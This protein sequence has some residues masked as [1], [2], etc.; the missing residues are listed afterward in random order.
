MYERLPEW[1]Q[2]VAEYVIETGLKNT[3]IIAGV[4]VVLAVVVGVLL[5]TLLTIRFLPLQAAIRLYI[6]VWRGLPIIVT[7]FLLFFALPTVAD[8]VHLSALNLDTMR[9]A[10]LGLALWGSAQIA[11]ATRGA[12]QSIPREQHEASAALGFGWIGRHTYVIL[13]QASRRLLPPLVGLCVGVIQNSTLAAIIGVPEVLETAQRSTNRL[14]VPTVDPATLAIEGGDSHA[15]EIY[16]GIFFL[17]FLI[18][19]PLTRLAAYLEKKL[20]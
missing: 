6:E 9:A 13:P 20:V 5:G 12:V 14:A 8:E 11:E 2:P 17:F 15:L 18:S 10:I 1:A 19:F 4:S 16:L 3:L 7:I